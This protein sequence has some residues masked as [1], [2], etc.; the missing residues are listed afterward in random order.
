MLRRFLLAA[1]MTDVNILQIVHAYRTAHCL[2]LTYI[3]L[4]ATAIAADE[5]AC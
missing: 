5:T 1:R 4:L 2:A 3:G